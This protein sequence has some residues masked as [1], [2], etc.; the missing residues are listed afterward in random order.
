MS[1]VPRKARVNDSVDY[2]ILYL[3]GEIMRS[4]HVKT[5]SILFELEP[6]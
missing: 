1:S 4:S 5:H 3:S 6:N 2:F